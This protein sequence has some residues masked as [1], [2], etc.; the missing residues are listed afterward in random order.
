MYTYIAPVTSDWPPHVSARSGDSLHTATAPV[1]PHETRSPPRPSATATS[2]GVHLHRTS[3]FR[4]ATAHSRDER[5]IITHWNSSAGFTTGETSYTAKVSNS[6]SRGGKFHI[7]SATSHGLPHVS[8][9]SVDSRH[10]ATALVSPQEI[11]S[12]PRSSVTATSEGGTF[13]LRRPL[14]S[15]RHTFQRGASIHYTMLRHVYHHRRHA[16]L[17]GRQRRQPIARVTSDWP[18]HVSARSSDITT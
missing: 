13:T 2:G 12:H 15:G 5:R 6:K 7:A 17:L 14:Q 10:T 11:R 8:K 16:V 9:R 4:L 1:S 3:H 18:P